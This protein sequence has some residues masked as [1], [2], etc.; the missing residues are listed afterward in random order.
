MSKASKE[1]EIKGG[2]SQIKMLTTSLK[3][4]YEALGASVA[5][6]RSDFLLALNPV[7]RVV[8]WQPAKSLSFAS[9]CIFESTLTKSS[10]ELKAR[11]L[12]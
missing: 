5:N 11:P 6:D 2:L 12:A 8:T 3:K 9:V 4:L 1:A 10:S 7:V